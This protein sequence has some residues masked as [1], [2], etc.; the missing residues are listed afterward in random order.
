MTRQVCLRGKYQPMPSP[1]DRVSYVLTLYCGH[2]WSW[3]TD[4]QGEFPQEVD[5]I[6]CDKEERIRTGVEKPGPFDSPVVLAMA[7]AVKKMRADQ[8][9]RD[10]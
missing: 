5:C 7:D 9:R 8:I 2:L 10:E 1:F 6:H 4:R 3:N